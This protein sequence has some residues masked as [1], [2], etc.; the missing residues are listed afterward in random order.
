MN[1]TMC[2]QYFLFIGRMC[3]SKKGIDILKNTDI[4]KH[5]TYL[6]AN[7]NHTIYVKLI[8]SGLDYTT[9]PYPRLIL[10]KAL[11]SPNQASRLYATQFLLVLL[12]ARLPTFE[13]W[14]VPLIMNQLKDADRAVMLATLEIIEEA[15]HENVYLLEFSHVWPDLDK[16]HEVGKYTMMRFYSIP[17]GLNH[18]NANV[19]D[20][21]DLWINV[22]NRKYVMFVESETHSSMTLHTKSEDGYY[23]SRN[24]V[25][26]RQM[27]K[28][29][30]LP[31]H[32]YGSLVQTQRGISHL[33]KFGNIT[34]LVEILT[35]GKC[36][37]E[38]ECLLMKSALWALGHVATNNDGIEFLNNPVSRVFEK[39]IQ[40]AKYSEVYSI[41]ATA[42]NV[43]CLMSSTVSGSNLLFKLDWISVRHDRNNK[44][45]ILEP[46]DWHLKN[47][48]PVRY[49]HDMAAYNYGGIDDSILLNL[50]GA[51]LN[52]SYFVEESIDSI[53]EDDVSKKF[54]FFI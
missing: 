47:P 7:T 37:N 36:G 40:L 13:E 51:A 28:T 48:S 16:Y 30:N 41:R 6:V 39:I 38:E 20:E 25:Q 42:F 29:T 10:E 2:Q 44:F 22:Y 31:C 54:T 26:Q 8:V 11:S 32:F 46:E 18:P 21:L 35:S 3:R 52:P 5:L 12:R 19:R 43:I 15:C 33:Q 49:N 50:S 17:R 53:R 24:S 4:L 9:Q 14:A 27:I 45:P 23:M 1:T 34:Q